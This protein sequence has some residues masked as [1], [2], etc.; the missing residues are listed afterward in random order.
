ML[1]DQGFVLVKLLWK[2]VGTTM[3]QQKTH[4]ITSGVDGLSEKDASCDMGP[5]NII[6]PFENDLSSTRNTK[7]YAPFM[8][9]S[10]PLHPKSLWS[11]LLLQP[12]KAGL[13]P[14]GLVRVL[15]WGR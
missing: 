3:Y 1:G 2:L 8:N 6:K 11:K 7:P 15:I 10:H 5:H 14:G 4:V 13:S 12:E 9:P